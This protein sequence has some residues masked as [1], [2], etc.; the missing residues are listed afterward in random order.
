MSKADLL[1]ND[2]FRAYRKKELEE[3]LA[4]ARELMNG[5]ATPEYANGALTMLKKIIL[6]PMGFEMGPK[7]RQKLNLLIQKDF[8]EL[9]FGLVKR[10]LDEE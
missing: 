1:F 10:F 5:K 3:G 6:I 8:D 2:D 9:H 7:Q 4:I